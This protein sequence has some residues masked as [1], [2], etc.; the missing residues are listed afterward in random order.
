[1]QDWM[2][3]LIAA[4]IGYAFGSFNPAILFS[5]LFAGKDIRTM[6]SGNAGST[7]VYRNLGPKFALA[8]LLCDL[9]K[10]VLAAVVGHFLCG[11]AGVE[12][13]L[14]GRFAGGLGAVL[15]H[16]FP[17][18]HGLRGGKGVV[19]AAGMLLVFDWRV[20]AVMFLV[21]LVF[22]V[23]TRYIS[24]GS[25]MA[26]AALPVCMLIFH[27]GHWLMFGEALLVGGLVI[28]LHRTNIGRLVKGCESKFYFKQKK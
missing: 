24:L 11:G 19:T 20:I 15:G 7:N 6:G 18:W 25:I 27:F 14:Y 2:K 26:A 22:S 21:F 3:L 10:G 4:V 5:R 23:S 16:A 17:L 1:M 9:L 28:W 8:V 12:L 13:S